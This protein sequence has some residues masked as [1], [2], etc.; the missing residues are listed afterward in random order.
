ML[1]CGGGD[2]L[3]RNVAFLPYVEYG[4]HFQFLTYVITRTL[5]QACVIFNFGS[6]FFGYYYHML[7]FS[8]LCPRVEKKIFKKGFKFIHCLP[9][10]CLLLGW[11]HLQFTISC[12]L[13]I[14][15]LLTKVGL[16][17]PSIS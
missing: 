9:E 7:S 6:H 16:G 4:M 15:M 3:K 17:W 10:N 5:A 14:Q 12:F 11:G 2:F 8:K 1:N 13:V